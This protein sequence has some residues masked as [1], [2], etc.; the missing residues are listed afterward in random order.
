MLA[1]EQGHLSAV[2][3]LLDK[4]ADVSAKDEKGRTALTFASQERHS[5]IAEFLKERGA[6]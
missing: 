5:M 3:L 4:G 2:Q 6:Q 1:S